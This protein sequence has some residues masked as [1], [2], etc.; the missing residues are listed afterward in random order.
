MGLGETTARLG[1][2][3]VHGPGFWAL[4]GLALGWSGAHQAFKTRVKRTGKDVNG[5][6]HQ[7][8]TRW[9]TRVICPVSARPAPG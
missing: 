2:R 5:I 1:R 4:V 6:T 3:A 7:N 8:E 9:K